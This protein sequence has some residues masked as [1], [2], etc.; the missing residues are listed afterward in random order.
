MTH[1]TNPILTEGRNPKL[2]RIAE[3]IRQN[4]SKPLMASKMNADKRIR[5]LLKQK[6]EAQQAK[7]FLRL[8]IIESQLLART[9]ELE[10]EE[11]AKTIHQYCTSGEIDSYLEKEDHDKLEA[12]NACIHILMDA[13]DSVC[14]DCIAVYDS[15]GFAPDELFIQKKLKEF[16]VF[17]DK[18]FRNCNVSGSMYEEGTREEGDRAYE[19]VRQRQ[20]VLFRKFERMEKKMEKADEGKNN[21]GVA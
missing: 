6:A 20:P 4:L 15:C 21:K 18:W 3:N 12:S 16:R 5:E 11:V 2:F 13:L 7:Q 9:S 14:N 17:V 10:Y 8:R 1:I 19:Y